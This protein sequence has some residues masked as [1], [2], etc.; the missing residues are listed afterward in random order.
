MT[1]QQKQHD[2]N[3]QLQLVL[4]HVHKYRS[5]PGFVLGKAVKEQVE[6]IKKINNEPLDKI[7]PY[8]EVGKTFIPS[9]PHC[10]T[11]ELLCGY[12]TNCTSENKRLNEG[13]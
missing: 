6:K 4:A 8:V 7:D 11:D 2:I 1:P 10:D 12:P 13:Y 3:N 5:A 9:C